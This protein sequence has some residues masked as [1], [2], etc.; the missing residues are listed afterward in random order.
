MKVIVLG[1]GVI[2]VCSAWYL[3]KKG[4]EVTVIDRQKSPGSETSFANAG[5]LSYGHAAPWAGPGV[6]FQAIKWMLSKN[7]PFLMRFQTDPVFIRW[8]SQLLGQC[9]ESAQSINKSRM[10]RLA[11]YSRECMT[12]LRAEVAL[13]FD[14][15]SKGTLELYR[16]EKSFIDAQ[17]HLHLLEQANV[18]YRVLDATACTE[19]EPGL[20]HARTEIFGGIVLPDDETGDCFKF[21]QNLANEAEKIGVK[22]IF[23]EE[24]ESLTHVYG[25]ISSVVTHQNTY[26][27]DI[28]VL[29]T[30]SFSEKILRPLG[31]KLP[32]QPIKGY[33]LTANIQDA[34]RAPISTILDDTAKVALTRLGDRVRVAGS[35]ELTG[36]NL[37]LRQSRTEMIAELLETLFPDAVDKNSISFWAGLRPSTP[38]GTPIIG[39]TIYKNLFLNVGHGTLGWTMGAGSGA[40]IADLISGQTPEIDSDDLGIKRF[41][42]AQG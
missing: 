7:A 16:T 22:F 3:A 24:I 36:F 34:T 5:E 18:A 17:A 13:D 30:G 2:G 40:L 25:K 35:A 29:A 4:Y 37:N 31:F 33:S 21:T 12:A 10:M 28:F 8:A 1:S 11:M 38:D 9:T 41:K 42:K 19:H 14:F 6:P 39:Q 32:V 23:E 26:S 20:K 27:A 15:Q